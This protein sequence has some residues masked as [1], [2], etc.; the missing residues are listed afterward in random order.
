MGVLASRLTAQ[1]AGT[2]GNHHV[3]GQ[4]INHAKRAA[5]DDLTNEMIAKYP[6]LDQG[7]VVQN[8]EESDSEEEDSSSEED[9]EDEDDDDDDEGDNGKHPVLWVFGF[10]DFW[11]NK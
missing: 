7:K 5:P 3:T 8:E 4:L 1:N 2:S 6:R 9:E 10:G 11:S